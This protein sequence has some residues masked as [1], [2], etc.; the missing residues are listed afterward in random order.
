MI[1]QLY[2]IRDTVADIFNRPFVAH[3]DADAIRAFTQSFEKGGQGNKE[4]Y[5]L[6]HIGS[7]NDSNGIIDTVEPIRVYSGLDIK[8]EKLKAV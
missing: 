3:N 8:E 1:K 4:D 5:V 2:T 6:Y 7:Y